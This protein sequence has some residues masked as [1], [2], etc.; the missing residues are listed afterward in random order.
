MKDWRGSEIRVGGT[1]VWATGYHNKKMSQGVVVSAED[2]QEVK[3]YERGGE[4]HQFTIHHIKI[5]MLN[6]NGN[7]CVLLSN[8]VTMINPISFDG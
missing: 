2:L 1:A 5:V 8:R 7:K 3:D 4:H 6:E